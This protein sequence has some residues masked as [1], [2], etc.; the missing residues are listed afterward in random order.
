LTELQ[1]FEKI[2]FTVSTG[3]EPFIIFPIDEKGFSHILKEFPL[4]LDNQSLIGSKNRLIF[5]LLT[6]K[7]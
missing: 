6:K 2:T 3:R 4:S 7:K 1:L 5:V